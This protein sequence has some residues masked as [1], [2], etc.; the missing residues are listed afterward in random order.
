MTLQEILF[1]TFTPPKVLR[2]R[3]NATEWSRCKKKYSPPKSR[4]Q[5]LSANAQKMLEFITEQ[6]GIT[7]NE[8]ADKLQKEIKHL[9]T[10]KSSLLSRDLIKQVRGAAGKRGGNYKNHF[11]PTKD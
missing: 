11:Y 8:L 3:R 6:P 4:K 1:G 5:Q 9:Y 10:V 7:L 2:T